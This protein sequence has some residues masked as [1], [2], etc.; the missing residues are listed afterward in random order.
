M[1]ENTGCSAGSCPFV[2]LGLPIGSNVN[3]TVN[4]KLLTDR[5]Y[6]K[7]S[8]WKA[9]LLSYGGRL[10]LLKTVLGSPGIYYLSIFKAL[11]LNSS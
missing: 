10:T 3:L 7:L 11:D 9:N 5:F 4:W 8:T 2:Y 1:A 6:A